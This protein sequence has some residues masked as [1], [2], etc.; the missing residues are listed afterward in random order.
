MKL[1][2]QVEA[3]LRQLEGKEGGGS[4]APR[5]LPS[6]QK[7]DSSRQ[8]GTAAATP[9]AYNADADVEMTDKKEKKK[10][11]KD[12][13]TDGEEK[14]SEKKEKKK[15]REKDDDE[16]GEKKKKKKKKKDD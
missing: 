8:N 2:V 1:S 14:K 11:K 10:K 15:K 3:R 13:E 9:K 16:D 7:Y 4:G 6:A 5:G 12:V